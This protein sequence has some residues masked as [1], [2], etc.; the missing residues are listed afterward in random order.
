[1]SFIP[2]FKGTTATLPSF[3]GFGNRA[4]VTDKKLGSYL[5]GKSVWFGENSEIINVK[6]YVTG[7]AGT[8]ANPYTGWDTA[9]TAVGWIPGATYVFTNEI[10]SFNTLHITVPITL[11]GQGWNTL[12][13]DN[14]G[15]AWINAGNLGTVLY[16]TAT[17]GVGLNLTGNSGQYYGYGLRDMM[18]VG[19]GTGTA[20]GVAMGSAGIANVNS[21]WSNVF[22][23]NF[24]LAVDLE[25]TE[26]CVFMYTSING[27]VTG[28]Y[29][30]LSTNQNT[31]IATNINH[32]TTCL[33]LFQAAQ[34]SFIGG[35]LQGG[36][37]TGVKL[38]G[39]QTFNMQDVYCEDV[40]DVFWVESTTLGST[41]IQISGVFTSVNNFIKFTGG[42]TLNGLSIRDCQYGGTMT[43]PSNVT[44]GLIR[45]VNTSAP[46]INNSANCLTVNGISHSS[47]LHQNY[48]FAN[49]PVGPVDG[50][51]AF[52][53]DATNVG[54]A[55]GTT[56]SAGGSTNKYLVLRKN[57]NWLV[58]G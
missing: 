14:F 41:N 54:A 35:L 25:N 6:A 31:F 20:T 37:T 11:Q 2:L 12:N 3:T 26:D 32:C 36:V 53:T 27:C 5:S 43:I 30:G 28:L 18:F 10:Y 45:N 44:N 9:I 1:M 50:Q 7:G 46:I 33:S 13:S 55:W 38:E 21:F 56:V 58:I 49:L 24:Y 57:G 22:F 47:I 4:I 40:H 34:N 48:T 51:V 17:S 42:V 39:V 23:A 19:P 52:V 29:L 15:G 16:C 8:S